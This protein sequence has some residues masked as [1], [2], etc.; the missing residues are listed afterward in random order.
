VESGRRS[1]AVAVELFVSREQ[2]LLTLGSGLPSV[3]LLLGDF[4]AELL[5]SVLLLVL[6]RPVDLWLRSHSTVGLGKGMTKVS[7]E[8]E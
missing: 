8:G 2:C 6:L 7:A 3:C 5:A 4:G 1:V